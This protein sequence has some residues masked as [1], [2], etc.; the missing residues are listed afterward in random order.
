[1]INPLDPETK[2]GGEIGRW[3]DGKY[4]E[5]YDE[6]GYFNEL[7]PVYFPVFDLQEKNN[8]YIVHELKPDIVKLA[9][10]AHYSEYMNARHKPKVRQLSTKYRGILLMIIGY[11]VVIM[12]WYFSI[13]L[14]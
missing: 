11:F 13:S 12:Q 7:P 2:K 14:M 8:D 6:D 5:G 3:I 10:W 1:M 4:H 9:F